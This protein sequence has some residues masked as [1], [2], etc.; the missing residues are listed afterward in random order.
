MTSVFLCHS[1]KDKAFAHKLF[2]LLQEK[3]IHVWYDEAELNIGDSLLDKITNAISKNDYVIAILSHNSINSR[4]VNY[5]LKIA[6]QEEMDKEKIKVL[7]IVIDN[8]EIPIYLKTKVYLDFSNQD[9]FVYPINRLLNSLGIEGVDNNKPLFTNIRFCSDELFDS[10][11]NGCK[12]S[13]N[14]FQR[15]IKKIYMSWNYKNVYRGM[16]FTRKWY[17]DAELWRKTDD[18]WDNNWDSDNQSNTTSTFILNKKGHP[19]GKY[20]VRLFIEDE[21]ICSGNFT[22]I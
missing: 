2:L 20:T 5:E 18:I 1:S 6:V 13:T 17:K 14:T 19:G 15:P 16:K 12:S 22:V 3:G 10:E 21:Y 11:C 7:P 4:W 8:C 9:D